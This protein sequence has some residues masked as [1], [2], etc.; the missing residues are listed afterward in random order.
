[1]NNRVYV[2]TELFQGWATIIEYFQN[3]PFFPIQIEL[4]E[5]DEDGHTYKRIS[6]EHIIKRGE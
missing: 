1:M 3:E 5:P 6:R 4:D 2:E